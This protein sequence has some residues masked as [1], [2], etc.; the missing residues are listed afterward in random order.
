MNEK[1]NL[2]ERAKCFAIAAHKAVGQRRKYSGD[3]YSIHPEEVALM[4]AERGGSEAMIAAA[5]LHD[6]VE[7]TK[8][9]N[10]DIRD[11]FD[12][13]VA[14]LVYWLTDVSKLTDG[15]RRIR[16][17]IDREHLAAAP[18]DA[19]TI[20]YCDS[21]LNTR[22]IAKND[23][24]FAAVYLPEKLADLE[25]MDKGDPELRAYAISQVKEAQNRLENGTSSEPKRSFV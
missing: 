15:N 1:S 12:D 7:D 17:A 10:D 25:A 4:V 2:I 14:D 23:P 6:T 20:K 13:E 18:A 24:K 22:D 8:V 11:L 5:W 21:I 16:K 9:A 19:Q 3:C